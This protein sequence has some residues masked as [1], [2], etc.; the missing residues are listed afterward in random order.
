MDNRSTQ[1]TGMA[2]AALMLGE[3]GETAQ[4][5]IVDDLFVPGDTEERRSSGSFR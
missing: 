1:E 5:V 3:L 4:G 2:V